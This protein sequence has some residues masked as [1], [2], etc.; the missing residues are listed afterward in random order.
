MDYGKPEGQLKT[1]PYAGL[2][3]FNH[4]TDIN[5]ICKVLGHDDFWTDNPDIRNDIFSLKD[6]LELP[7]YIW[8][9]SPQ[10][11]TPTTDQLWYYNGPDDLTTMTKSSRSE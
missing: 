7:N 4:D 10:S 6:T 1:G 2:I 11:I 5:T 8:V 3:G 9:C